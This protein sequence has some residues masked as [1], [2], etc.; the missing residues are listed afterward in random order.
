MVSFG[1]S[2]S[3]PDG[4]DPAVADP[5]VAVVGLACRLPGADGP[6]EFW[7]LLRDG[8]DAVGTAPAGRGADGHPYGGFLDRVDTFDADF[9]GISPREAAA[10]DPQQ[11]L[12]LELAWEA[13]EDA[14]IVPDALRGTPTGVFVGAMADDYATLV[15]RQGT[16]ALDRYAMTGL[17]RGMVANRIS[18]VLG[19]RGPSLTV[20]TAQS[21]SLVSVQMACESLRRGESRL[22]LAG[23][24]HLNIAPDSTVTAER[25][26]G[27]SPDGRCFTFDA[28]ANGFVRGE[29]GGLVVLKLLADAVADGD[30]VDCVILGGAVN[31]D[32]VSDGLTVPNG[33]AQQEVLRLSHRRAGVSPGDVQ[34]LELHGSGTPVGDPI[35]AASAGGV[36]GAGRPVDAP[37]PVGS[38]KTNIGHLEGAGGIAGLLK[39]VLSIVHRQLPPSLHHDT[40]NPAIPFDDLRIRVRRDLGPWPHPDRPLL[41]GVSSF[42][43]G[44]TNCHLVVGQPPPVGAPADAGDQVD[45]PVLP[46][47]VPWVL[48]GRGVAAVAGQARRLL[49]RVA[50]G[51]PDVEDV[52]LS[53]AVSRA[54]LPDRAVLFGADRADLLAGLR[55][56]ADGPAPTAVAGRDVGGAGRVFV[57]PGQG[58]QWRGMGAELLE[59]SAVFREQ[60]ARCGT[61]LAPYVDWSLAGVLRGDAGQPGLDRVDVVQPVAWAVMVSLAAVW[62]SVG[63]TP[64]AVVG[65]SQGEIAAAVVAGA[66][67]VDDGARVVALRSRLIAGLPAGGGMLSVAL[68][69]EEATALIRDLPEVTVAAVNGVSSTVLSGDLTAL[70]E[71]RRTLAG[72]DVPVRLLPVDY[73][74]HSA[75][76]EALRA[77]LAVALADVRPAPA[78]VP[79][80]SAMT[81]APLDPA[82]LTGDYWYRNLRNPVRFDTAVRT[83][84]AAGHRL[85]L[86]VSGHPVLVVG[87]GELLDEAEVTGAALGT[88]RRDDGGSDRFWRS[89]GEAWAHGAP[90]DWA[91]RFPHGRLVDLPTYAFQRRRHW[92][93][94]AGTPE[95]TAPQ[96]AAPAAPVDTPA[97]DRRWD[98]GELT[99]LVRA[100]VAVVLGHRPEAVELDRTFKDLGFD[101]LGSVELRNRL[102]TATGRRLPAGLLFDHPTPAALVRHLAGDRPR[103]A[104]A[105]VGAAHDEPIVITAMACRLPGGVTSPEDLWRVVADGLDVTSAM[106]DNRAWDLA[107]LG[108]PD[109]DRP[110]TSHAMRGGFLHDAGDFDAA[111]FDISPREATAM[112]PQ[113]RLLLETSWEAL[114]RAGIDPG[115][116]RGTPVGVF[117]GAMSQDYGP[118][119]HQPVAGY[120]GHLLTGTTASV[121]SGR[122]AYQFGFEGPA[123]TVDTA[124]SSSLVALHLAGQALRAGD[125][126]LALAGGVAVMTKPG[127]FVEFSRQGGLAPDGR[128]KPYASAA[129]GTAWAEGVGMLVVQRLSDARRRGHP[130]LAVIRGSA[131]NQDGASN[132]LTA[133]NGPSQVRVI[134]RALA[135]G[136]LTPSDVDV[137]EGHGTGTRLGDPIEAGALIEAYGAG[138]AVDAPLW[139]GSVKSN[140]G[141]AQAAAGVAGVIKMV[142][143]LRHRVLPATVHVDEPS[144]HVDWSA[145]VRLLTASRDWADGARPR[146]A[147][148]SSFGI[149]GTNAHVILEQAPDAVVSDGGAAPAGGFTGSGGAGDG[150]PVVWPVSARSATG[151]RQVAARLAEHVRAGGRAGDGGAPVG[152]GRDLADIAHTLVTGRAALPHRAV[153]VG[154]SAD[155]LLSGLDAVGR[156]EP[157]G[158]VVQGRA[159]EPG[160]TVFV[161]PGQGSQWV[162][163]GAGL[164]DASP[165]FAARV[166]E[167]ERALAPL[168]DWSL[169][170]VLGGTADPGLLDRVDVVQPVLWAVMVS[171]AAVWE[172]H[173]VRPDAVVGHSQGEIAAA[174]VAGALSLA[175]GARVVALRSRAIRAIAG[176]GGMLAVSTTA[177]HA[178]ALTAPWESTV[179]VAAVNGPSAVVLSGD[180]ASLEAIV[181]RC[182][183]D[184]IR[185]RRI[186]VDYASHTHHVE[187]IRE[188]LGHALTGLRPKQ[189]TVAFHS[190]TT[191]NRLADTTT[192]DGDY[193]YHNLRTTVLFDPTVRALAG[194][195]YTTFVEVS[196]HPVL[197][198][199]IQDTLDTT[200]VGNGLAVGTLKRDHGTPAQF[201]TNLAT[202][203]THGHRVTWHT[204]GQSTD[205]PTYPFQHRHHWLAAGTGGGLSGSGLGV[206]DHP[207]L[208]AAVEV[209]GADEVVLTGSL[210]RHSHPWLADHAVGDTV[211][212]PGTALVE[213]ALHTGARVG[214]DR[215]DEL[216]LE[217]P[218][219]IDGPDALVVQVVLTGADEA[220]RRTVRVHSRPDRPETTGGWVRHAVG[221]LSPG[222]GSTPPA[223]G[224]D[225]PPT[226]GQPVDLADA[227]DRLADRG[228]HYGPVFQGLTAL[229]RSGDDLYVEAGLGAGQHD[230]AGAYG[231]HPALLDAVL[232]AVL[233]DRQDTDGDEVALP[234]S[235]TGVRLHTTGA[236]ALRA[237][238]RRAGT[239]TVSVTA[240][241]GTGRPVIGIEELALRPVPAGRLAGRAAPDRNL[242]VLD[243]APATTDAPPVG[244]LAALGE[245]DLVQQVATG[246]ALQTHYDLGSLVDLTVYGGEVPAAVL[247]DCAVDPRE[248][249]PHAAR[250]VTHHLLD[251]VQSWLAD[252]RLA[253]A[254]LVLLTRGATA[255]GAGEEVT[256]L[257]GSAAR[258]L[259]RSAQ[260]EHPGR[261]VLVDL[262]DDAASAAALGA[263]LATG[264][265]ELAIRRGAVLAPRLARPTT[266]DAAPG[267]D[268]AD[269]TVLITGGTGTLG[270]LLARRL[271]GEG[272][273]RDVLLVGRRGADSPG[274]AE[275]AGELTE[276]GVR[277]EVAACDVSDRRALAAL[278]AA[279]PADRP[280][281]AVIHAAGVLDDATVETLSPHQVDA[282]FRPKVDAAWHLHELTAHLDL[283]AFV[284]FSS[285][286][287]T[288]GTAGQAGYAAANAFLDALARHRRGRGL[289]AVAM[290]WGLWAASSGMTGHLGGADLARL[291]RA[292]LAPLPTQEGL[293]LFDRALAVNAA[294]VLPV[295][296]DLPA[297]RAR[298]ADDDLP[299][300]FHG[301]V[302][303]TAR[304]AVTAAAVAQAPAHSRLAELDPAQQHTALLDLVRGT[305]AAVLAY[306]SPEDVEAGRSLVELGVDSLTAVEL[307]NRLQTVTGLRLSTTLVFDYPTTA[308]IVE[309]LRG[310]LNP[311]QPSASDQVRAELDRLGAVI[312]EGARDEE[313]RALA[314]AYLRKLLSELSDLAS[315][316]DVLD[317]IASASDDEM[318]ALIDNEL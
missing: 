303:A 306:D 61:A 289:P 24:V 195:G 157:A 36:L 259:L 111:F 202:L 56:L 275:L 112:D 68:G 294:H 113:Q 179:S 252:D 26:G 19:L 93:P 41:A 18:Y 89:A 193:W 308:A 78:R 291:T 76:M 15:R 264:E 253:G 62:E 295:A 91:R 103:S 221:T 137:V 132:G 208:R 167:C 238:I 189:A 173:G 42:G 309:H 219:V 57:F 225:R 239:D 25:F 22:A 52:G 27:L 84:L 288:L 95:P 201:L 230:A 244:P 35:E 90:V 107:A 73:A 197:T 49:D 55:E 104:P 297:L 298:A 152:A 155:D 235:F 260:T 312:T 11:R 222:S 148:V 97:G 81:G 53:L 100:T 71:L 149:S 232:H 190:T 276:A 242:F 263:A 139:L 217:T 243:W 218:C 141:H 101:S 17:H 140:I 124:C 45:R 282:V 316:A 266:T 74:S 245:G 88:L 241:D 315:D 185:V 5:P 70:Q 92:L 6:D 271:A 280:L 80:V 183:A 153:V 161:F 240:V 72:R 186:P 158:T 99:T 176:R 118:P 87:V 164:L 277:V 213:L 126:D 28:R 180:P 65:H 32:G 122:I 310:E 278:L 203:H 77:D 39:V 261:F 265:P 117:V 302:A 143:A 109:R 248:A 13:L 182:E 29:G 130:I 121:A 64:S 206:V 128:C 59:S 283:S 67:S 229:R 51:R 46:G 75:R 268:V 10:T 14:R 154:G 292:G 174:C 250:S 38:V 133:P 270:G 184:G 131:V 279:I 269:G 296:L 237:R 258:G 211:L 96:A 60:V 159:G 138:R 127:L 83:L 105:R 135:A 125:C 181:A 209:A 304:R 115:T 12:V 207:L 300:V 187:A 54:A 226:G 236:T 8:V 287:G 9:F 177:E 136:G 290:A 293:D 82:G 63:V 204:G 48:S 246:L 34:Y 145:G 168:V 165:V 116:L 147:G 301:V 307:R 188:D 192:L 3:Q 129:D 286:A 37:L 1:G 285:V 212:L 69:V 305:V 66:L 134:G 23:G 120:E 257:A 318:F 231:L 228:Y 214:A 166:A 58:W 267:P 114:E 273:L 108:H 146:R 178:R 170:A 102:S 151:L 220:G 216:T 274:T 156:G 311:S 210:S 2:V 85:F 281:R 198:M 31:H 123:V 175:D 106:P 317:K 254:R 255:T 234:F 224:S 191:G 262:D 144:S 200:G 299:T 171:L 272:R 142:M 194:D 30:R 249:V 162:G 7:A 44:G 43:M 247:V 110:G 94:T 40:P 233:L 313:A 215:L 21:S 33:A 150:V 160:R 314:T 16:G 172:E 251:V 256:D 47:P 199:A 223:D 169:T 119:L 227:Y 50:A 4:A 79:M 98:D 196:P 163:M 284:L 205:L 86:E 20:D